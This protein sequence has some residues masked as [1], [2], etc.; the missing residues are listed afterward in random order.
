M[1]LLI[2]IH[3]YHSHDTFVPSLNDL[4]E[5]NLKTE[6]L[7]PRI[8]CRPESSEYVKIKIKLFALVN[9]DIAL[10]LVSCHHFCHN[11]YNELSPYLPNKNIAAFESGKSKDV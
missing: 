2:Y 6:W 9:F 11:L 7:L 4:S 5:S 8:F 1:H 3:T 10:T